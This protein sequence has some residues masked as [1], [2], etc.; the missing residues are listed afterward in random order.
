MSS[1]GKDYELLCS[2]QECDGQ[3]LIVTTN[4]ITID[5]DIK[6]IADIL[7]REFDENLLHTLIK[8]YKY[9]SMLSF[10]DFCYL[11]S[12]LCAVRELSNKRYEVIIPSCLIEVLTDKYEEILNKHGYKS[13]HNILSGMVKYTNCSLKGKEIINI[14]REDVPLSLSDND[15]EN[16]YLLEI[17]NHGKRFKNY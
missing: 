3:S 7:R 8:R 11:S 15:V 4:W 2:E 1:N 12:D 6:H 17:A 9:K 5:N 14:E 13:C 16:A 10:G